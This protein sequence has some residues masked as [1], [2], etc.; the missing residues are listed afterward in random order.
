MLGPQ[1]VCGWCHSREWALTMGSW[2][3]QTVQAAAQLAAPFAALRRNVVNLSVSSSPSS[4]QKS[5]ATGIRVLPFEWSD[6]VLYFVCG[7][8]PQHGLMSSVYVHA[9]DPNLWIPGHWSRVYELNHY[10]TGLAPIK[11]R[12]FILLEAPIHKIT[13]HRDLHY[14]QYPKKSKR[15]QVAFC[16]GK[17]RR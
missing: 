15:C 1:L 2:A 9:W 6:S 5:S 10:A 17:L 3:T 14:L 16:G 4:R 11:P 13:S 8:P 12:G 7:M